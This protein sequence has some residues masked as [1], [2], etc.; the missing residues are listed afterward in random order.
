MCTITAGLMSGLCIISVPCK[1]D[2]RCAGPGVLRYLLCAR[3][4]FNR[5]RPILVLPY[6]QTQLVRPGAF[7]FCFMRCVLNSSCLSEAT[8]KVLC[9]GGEGGRVPPFLGVCFFGTSCTDIGVL[10]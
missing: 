8:V 3:C 4:M 5:V 9:G 10:L 1:L 2:A 7:S 6:R